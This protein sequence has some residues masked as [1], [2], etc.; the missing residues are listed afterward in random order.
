MLAPT[1]SRIAAP[2]VRTPA[3]VLLVALLLITASL[4]ARAPIPTLSIPLPSTNPP[5]TSPPHHQLRGPTATFDTT[6]G[7]L[8]IIADAQANQVHVAMTS[9]SYMEV[10]V[11]HRWMSSDPGSPAYAAAL[12]GLTPATVTRIWLDSS[13]GAGTLVLDSQHYPASLQIGTDGSLLIAGSVTARDQLTISAHTLRV[14]GSVGGSVITLSSTD[15][16]DIP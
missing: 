4:A 13:G 14:E 3:H 10:T 8:L 15:L 1:R 2:L 5:I 6:S 9:A 16:L 11:D 7:L 12:A